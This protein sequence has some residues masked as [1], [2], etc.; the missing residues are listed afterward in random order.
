MNA[1]K[2]RHYRVTGEDLNGINICLMVG[3][4]PQPVHLIDISA[5]GA[6]IAFLDAKQSDVESLVRSTRDAPVVRIE[7]A[8]LQ[9]SL[10]IACRVAHVQEVAAGVVCGVAFLRR[11]DET[12]NLDR[13]LLRIFNRRGAVRVEPDSKSPVDVR[14]CTPS[15]TQLASGTMRDMS[16]TGIGV[17]IAAADMAALPTGTHVVTHFTIDAHKLAMRA[18]VRFGKISTSTPP[19]DVQ[20]TP[21]GL[22]GIEFEPDDRNNPTNRKRIANWVMGRQLEIQ[23]IQREA[24]ASDTY[25]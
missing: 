22:L 10:N 17:S 8:R 14:L 12:F 20:P 6:A 16:L 15:G 4:E 19:G 23:R 11:V 5:A 25:A 9:E 18:Q 1:T 7:S 13:A 2:R 21:I 3:S 24:A